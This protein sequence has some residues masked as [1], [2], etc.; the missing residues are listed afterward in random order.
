MLVRRL[1]TQKISV[2][3]VTKAALGSPELAGV[4]LR[5]GVTV[6]GDSRIE[7]IETMRRAGISAPM[8]LVRSPMLSQVKR[9]VTNADVSFNTEVDVI[10]SLSLA[11][12]EARV[13]HGVVLM[14]ELGD[15]R[16]GIMPDDLIS[17]AQ[18]TLRYPNITLAGIG[19]NLAC[20]S[21]VSPDDTNMAELSALAES[22]EAKCDSTIE[23]VSGGNSANL[24]WALNGGETGRI[25]NLRL[26]ESILLGLDPLNRQP[27]EGLH[28]DA[29]ALI[30]EVIESKAKPSRPW[31]EIA[32]AAFGNAPQHET[33]QSGL[34]KSISQTILAIGHQDTDPTGL[35]LD[36]GVSILGA[37][38]D[39]LILD[40]GRFALRPGSE[41]T[42]RPNYSAL[43]RAMASPFVTQVWKPLRASVPEPVSH[44]NL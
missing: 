3:G 2:T 38:S 35:Q 25:N 6:L 5:A 10:R 24:N 33:S 7:N 22:I 11:A 18:K 8:T 20:R 41:M 16:E 13:T 21:G 9:V 36:R 26:G 12:Q 34:S 23:I 15:L 19:T 4:M 29:I 39:H 43:V 28:T 1:Q 40:T 44:G 17:I 30:A 32:E 31:G 14:I 27:I 37:S 42:T